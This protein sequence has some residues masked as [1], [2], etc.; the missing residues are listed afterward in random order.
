MDP[1]TLGVLG[2]KVVGWGKAIWGAVPQHLKDWSKS[3]VLNFAQ[4]KVPAFFKFCRD[5]I[6][7][8]WGR[9]PNSKVKT[10][11]DKATATFFALNDKIPIDVKRRLFEEITGAKYNP[12]PECK[13]Q[14]LSEIVQSDDE[15]KAAAMQ[16]AYLTAIL[17]EVTQKQELMLEQYMSSLN[18]AEKL[19]QEIM[20]E[21]AEAEIELGRFAQ[22]LSRLDKEFMQ[23]SSE[24]AKARKEANDIID[25][26]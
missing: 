4:K 10:A 3:E 5:K 24:T 8:L 15:K 6:S 23:I 14:D 26:I 19:K 13:M 17:G 1:I 7:S 20:D 11:V 22:E 18:M 9:V 2:M 16:M 12:D 25:M 21:M